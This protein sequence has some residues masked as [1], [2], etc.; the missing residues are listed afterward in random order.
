M[1]MDTM[2]RAA[3]ALKKALPS[4]DLQE[5]I[6]MARDVNGLKGQPGWKRFE[7][8]LLNRRTAM[9]RQLVHGDGDAVEPLRAKVAEL[10]AIMSWSD[11]VMDAGVA[12]AKELNDKES[13]QAWRRTT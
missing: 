1:A 4:E 9:D 7:S 10:D 3:R 8:F 6:S 12:A 13:E 2:Y 11:A 5:A